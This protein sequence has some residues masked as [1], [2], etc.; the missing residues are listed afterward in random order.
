MFNTEISTGLV[1]GIVLIILGMFLVLR[2]LFNSSSKSFT[3]KGQPKQIINR[4]Q[5]FSYLF[6]DPRWIPTM[7][8]HSLLLIF[9]PTTFV[10]IG[11][12]LRII[13]DLSRDA[14]SVLPKWKEPM[15]MFIEGA[16]FSLLTIGLLIPAM[17]LLALSLIPI[18]GSASSL[19]GILFSNTS[20]DVATQSAK[21]YVFV[22]SLIFYISLVYL[23]LVIFALPAYMAIYA[24][25]GKIQFKSVYSLI[26]NNL[27]AFFSLWAMVS[28]ALAIC[29][30]LALIPVIGVVVSIAGQFWVFTV[31][32]HSVGQ[33]C[34]LP[35][36]IKQ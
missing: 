33:I 35:K 31:M 17:L 32:A 13:R 19:L 23:F 5:A 18:L 12:E 34:N 2:Y 36:N 7:V 15:E 21:E 14:N 16:K 22:F 3:N 8:I 28:L 9:L 30:I 1:F 24:R 27:G 25:N 11:Y 4:G 20:I 26:A 10:A 29:S 6:H